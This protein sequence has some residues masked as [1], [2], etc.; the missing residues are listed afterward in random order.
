M[1]CVKFIVTSWGTL[2][3][4]ILLGFKKTPPEVLSHSL[5]SQFNLNLC[6]RLRS[7]RSHLYFEGFYARHG[8]YFTFQ[9][10]W[11]CFKNITFTLFSFFR[12]QQTSDTLH[13]PQLLMT[14]TNIWTLSKYW[15]SLLHTNQTLHTL[16]MFYSLL[17]LLR[18]E[19][20]FQFYNITI[21]MELESNKTGYVNY[22]S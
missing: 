6:S 10:P 5:T 11:V 19:L 2:P 15:I 9:I 20:F 12:L 22:L 18:N 3:T 8:L 7:Q 13:F 1:W 4:I 17:A 16:L 14:Q 21:T